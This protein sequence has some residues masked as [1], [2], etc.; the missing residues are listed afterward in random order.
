[1]AEFV[2]VVIVFTVLMTIFINYFSE[3]EQNITTA[4]FTA[5]SQNFNSTVVFVHAQWLMDLQPSTVWLVAQSEEKRIGVSVNK[6][7][8]LDVPRQTVK[9]TN[10]TPCEYIWQLAMEMPMELMKS[11]ITTIELRAK[12]QR[13]FRH[14][15][16]L[17]PSGQYFEYY[18]ETGKVTKVSKTESISL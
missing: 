5:I 8:W 12:A 1:M 10:I 15:R 6:R 3:Q 2:V 17:L 9:L 7:G 18:S 13:D 16:Y 11:P 14:C 4:G